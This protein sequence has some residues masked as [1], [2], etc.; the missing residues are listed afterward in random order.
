M[1]ITPAEVE[2]SV[3]DRSSWDSR[4]SA[5][6]TWVHVTRSVERKIGTPGKYVNDDVAST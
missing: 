2:P 6:P 3:L 4:S 1:P 5:L